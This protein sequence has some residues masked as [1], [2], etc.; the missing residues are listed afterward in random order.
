MI[1]GYRGATKRTKK[2]PKNHYKIG[3]K[4]V[5]YSKLTLPNI[6]WYDEVIKKYKITV[7]IIGIKKI[8][9]QNQTNN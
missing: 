9:I 1:K 8:K 6:S 4:G 7:L 2:N 5:P 3:G